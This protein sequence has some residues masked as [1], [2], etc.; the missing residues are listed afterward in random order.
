MP[1]GGS[2]GKESMIRRVLAGGESKRHGWILTLFH[3]GKF[4]LLLVLCAGT[5]C[6]EED[7]GSSVQVLELFR[8]DCGM[9]RRAVGTA[10]AAN[11]KGGLA[12]HNSEHS[13]FD[14]C[15][16]VIPKHVTLE[17]GPS[18]AW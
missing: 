10:L 16:N 4:L 5:S 7:R 1:A 13:P 6:S 11:S 12:A 17:V 3:R 8:V 14:I 9:A 2:Q 15:N 18:A